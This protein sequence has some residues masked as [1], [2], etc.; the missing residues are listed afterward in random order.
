MAQCKGLFKPIRIG[1]IE[2]RNRIVM[3]A[4]GLGYAVEGR[5]TDRL[6]AFY[7]E[8]ARGGAGLI[9]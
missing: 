8:R 2:L 4:L 3:P 5:V 9:C 6:K 1:Q 7:A